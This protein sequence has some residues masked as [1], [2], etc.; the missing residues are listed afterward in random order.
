M[1]PI[2]TV[3]FARGRAQIVGDRTPGLLGGQA[4]RL[5]CERR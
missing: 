3:N 4:Q 2:V 1:A 5:L